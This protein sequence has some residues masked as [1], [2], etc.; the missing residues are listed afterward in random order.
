[1]AHPSKLTAWLETAE[2]GRVPIHGTLSLGR[3]SSNDLVLKDEKISRRHALIHTQEENEYWLVDFGSANG[4]AVNGRRIV[5]PTR[6]NAGDAVQLAD[7]KFTFCQVGTRR[8]TV[9]G[10]PTSRSTSFETKT[11]TCWL[12]LADIVSSTSMSEKHAEKDLPVLLGKWFLDCKRVIDENGG[13]I[14]KFL[15]DGFF[16]Y[17]HDEKDAALRVEKALQELRAV[18]ATEQPR[19]RVALHHGEVS[20]GGSPLLV[21]ELFGRSV[22]FV[23]R[24]EKLGGKLGVERLLSAEAK[25][26]LPSGASAAELGTHP[27]AGFRGEFSF[28]SSP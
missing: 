22:N 21:E 4:S 13:A 2:G 28:F 16:A 14:N 23:F 10:R 19:F 1:M 17:W 12:L 20:V 3:S 6:L 27:L 24:M 9:V 11:T 18:Q 8:P 25:K 15:G 5:Q 26:N 7:T